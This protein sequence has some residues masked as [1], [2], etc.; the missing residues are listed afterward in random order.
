MLVINYNRCRG[1]KPKDSEE[2]I[3]NS[4]LMKDAKLRKLKSSIT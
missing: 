2:L 1:L 3:L 4:R